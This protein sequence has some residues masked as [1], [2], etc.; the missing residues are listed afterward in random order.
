MTDD[1][2]R[3]YI[4]LDWELMKIARLVAELSN[5]ARVSDEEISDLVVDPGKAAE[6]FEIVNDQAQFVERFVGDLVSDLRDELRHHA[7]G[8]GAA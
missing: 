3:F 6:R 4:K 8:S 7:K 1:L 2:K 5:E